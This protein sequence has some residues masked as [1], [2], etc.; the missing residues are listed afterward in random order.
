MEQWMVMVAHGWKSAQHLTG[1]DQHS[2]G[3]GNLCFPI[4][5]DL[6]KD[7]T[8]LQGGGCFWETGNERG[9]EQG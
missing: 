8:A 4:L 2:S 9:S 1:S 7:P 6:M 5:L 3:S